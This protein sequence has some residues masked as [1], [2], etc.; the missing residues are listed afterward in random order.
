MIF[1]LY[2]LL[3]V[4]YDTRCWGNTIEIAATDMRIAYNGNSIVRMGKGPVLGIPNEIQETLEVI[5]DYY[6]KNMDGIS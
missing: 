6:T 1:L 5:S 2:H 3:K 4:F